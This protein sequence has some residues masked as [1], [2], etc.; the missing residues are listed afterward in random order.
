MKKK[1]V[2]LGLSFL[3][4]TSLVLASCGGAAPV[5][6][7]EEYTPDEV[8]RRREAE[9][10]AEME[11]VTLSMGETYQT[12]WIKVTV[13]DQIITDSYEWHDKNTGELFTKEAEPGEIFVIAYVEQ[14]NVG[15]QIRRDEG[16]DRFRIYDAE[17]N[18][19]RSKF[20]YEEKDAL[21]V[22]RSFS[23]DE[24][25][26][27]KVLFIIPEGTSGLKIGYI[28]QIIPIKPI[29]QWVVE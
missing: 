14:L 2:W 26:E 20:Y 11:V 22:A 27:G 3:L 13:S 18:Y 8:R 15:D 17:G 29:A 23:P 4:V 16:R 7:E 10:H 6:E 12:E 5:E 24:R 28:T 9:E 21:L 19:W 25:A 1:I